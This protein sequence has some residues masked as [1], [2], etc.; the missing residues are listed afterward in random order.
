MA[1]ELGKHALKAAFPGEAFELGWQFIRAERPEFADV[2]PE[3][4]D[5]AFETSSC[6][7]AEEKQNIWTTTKVKTKSEMKRSKTMQS[8]R[9]LGRPARTSRK[10]KGGRKRNPR[11]KAKRSKRNKERG[12]GMP[13]EEAREKIEDKL[14][15]EFARNPDMAEAAKNALRKRELE[16]LAWEH[17]MKVQNVVQSALIVVQYGTLWANQKILSES[18]DDLDDICRELASF[19]T[20]FSG[21][22]PGKIK[23]A[24]DRLRSA[25]RQRDQGA[26]HAD[27]DLPWSLSEQNLEMAAADLDD[28]EEKV[29]KNIMKLEQARAWAAANG[30]AAAVQVGWAFKRVFQVWRRGSLFSTNGLLSMLN[31]GG[32]IPLL[33]WS[34]LQVQEAGVYIAHLT[35]VHHGLRTIA[36]DLNKGI[37]VGKEIAV[38]RRP[39]GSAYTFEVFNVTREQVWESLNKMGMKAERLYGFAR[40]FFEL[41]DEQSKEAVRRTQEG[42]K[43]KTR[44]AAR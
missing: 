31:L 20:R 14:A 44:K 8:R 42:A 17:S 33:G 18:S 27:S 13:L 23:D 30:A 10:R 34:A 35:A 28:L 6:D 21:V 7:T 32:S 41:D 40:D 43:A 22:D 12:L 36:E 26:F 39:K 15:P 11:P 9:K 37:P 2:W 4:A 25:C 16:N 1:F 5:G 19:R 29:W 24:R 38:K 3:F